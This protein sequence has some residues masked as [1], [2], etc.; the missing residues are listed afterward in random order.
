MKNLQRYSSQY[1][2]AYGTSA[3]GQSSFVIYI[4]MHFVLLQIAN[5]FRSTYVVSVVAYL[6]AVQTFAKVMNAFCRDA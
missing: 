1:W 4:L 2:L 6:E 3:G 5:R